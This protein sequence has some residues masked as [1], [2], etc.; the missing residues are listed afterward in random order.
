MHAVLVTVTID[1]RE[2]AAKQVRDVV[3]PQV[4][5]APGHVAG[6]WTRKGS[7]GTSIVVFESEQAADAMAA[8]V[9]AMVPDQ[10]TLES[11][12]VREV[13]ARS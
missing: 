12:E 7:S 9:P 13:V 1:D 10:V 4:R 2:A 6:F 5:Q 8:K 3:A 11:V